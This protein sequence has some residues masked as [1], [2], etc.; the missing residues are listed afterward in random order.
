[1]VDVQGREVYRFR[2][3]G[4]SQ[5]DANRIASLWAIENNYRG[6]L[7]VLP[8]SSAPA[9]QD[10]AS[11][12]LQPT[13]PGPWEVY[14]RRTGN[15]VL[16]LISNGE[17]VTNRGEAQRLAMTR[18]ANDQIDNYGV[19]TRGTSGMS[20]IGTQTDMENR[21]GLPSQSATAN[22]AVVDR[23]TL[24]P[25]FRFRAA[26]RRDANRIYGEWLAAAGLPTTTEDFGFQEIRPQPSEIPRDWRIVDRATD[27]TLNTVRGASQDQA[28]AVRADTARRHGVDV[29]QLSLQVIFNPDAAQGGIVDIAP[30]VAQNFPP[31]RTDGR[32]TNYS[33]RDLFGTTPQAS[34]APAG[35]SFSGQWRV[36]L[37]G[38]EVWRFRGPAGEGQ[39]NANRIAQLWYRDQ[40]SQ[41]LLSP[42][43]GADLEVVPVM[44]ESIQEGQ[45]AD[46]K[47]HDI[48]KL[49][50]ILSR[51][52]QMV[53]RGQQV[54]PKRYGQVAACVIDP[55]NNFVYGINLPG[56]N[57]Q[58]QHAERVAIDKYRKTHGD[59]PEGSIIVT[60]CS[61]CNSPMD[62]RYGESCKDLL[63]SVGIHKV[64]AG[65]IDPT[66]HDDADAD[67]VTQETDNDKLWG[68]CQLFA[69]TFLG[70]E[71]LVANE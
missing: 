27:E 17:P 32:D 35:N 2:D 62:E 44:I 58:R 48:P 31:D 50:K 71:E 69:Q 40:I 68:R 46:Y 4:N 1:M 49:D 60:T 26:D 23:E 7:E 43:E 38:E 14:N 41:G 29:S 37:D 20:N 61:P 51:C 25:V 34:S 52:C 16:N 53:I 11:N 19:R 63:N 6:N 13:G 28:Q 24:D 70:S 45:Q 10:T 55:D 9:G 8:V 36:M 30:D 21:L 67:F 18:I 33:F 47:I 39:A 22:Y 5:A 57:G 12:P 66:Q 56:P 42:A 54:D 59:I 3:E 65:Y 64:Y 15:T